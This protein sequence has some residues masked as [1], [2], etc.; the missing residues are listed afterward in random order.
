[1]KVSTLVFL[2]AGVLVVIGVFLATYVA[3]NLSRAEI[4]VGKINSVGAHNIAIGPAA[5]R[6]QIY[7]NLINENMAFH[8]QIS[9][10]EKLHSLGYVAPEW[11][12]ITK[13]EFDLEKP[14]FIDLGASGGD[15]MGS[16]LNFWGYHDKGE[17]NKD[18]WSV[19]KGD[20]R[21]LEY[22][23]LSNNFEFHILMK[24]NEAHSNKDL[25]GHSNLGGISSTD[26]R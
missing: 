7:G 23:T 15:P 20:R 10:R 1:M 26:D 2:S 25:S 8:G 9:M 24:K 4:S 17:N 21:L 16:S 18:T 13:K 3:P 5:L 12:E 22:I 11:T 6:E 19:Y 14:K